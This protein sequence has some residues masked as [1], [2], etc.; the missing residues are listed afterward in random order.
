MSAPI[1]RATVKAVSRRRILSTRAA[2]TLTPSAVNKV[3][4]L[5]ENKPQYIGLKVGVRTRGCNG[6]TYTLDY[7]KEKDKSDEEVVQD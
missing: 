7:T 3:K 6:L 4:L 2:L 1:V 5:L